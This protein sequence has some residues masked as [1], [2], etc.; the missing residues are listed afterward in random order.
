[1]NKFD[2]YK[3][4]AEGALKSHDVD[5]IGAY[6]LATAALELCAAYEKLNSFVKRF[7]G[8]SAADEWLETEI[9]NQKLKAEV[10][11]AKVGE[12]LKCGGNFELSNS[13][14]MDKL[15]EWS[16]ENQKLRTI[17]DEMRGALELIVSQAYISGENCDTVT[18]RQALDRVYKKLGEE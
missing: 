12:C 15:L 5:M 11:K 9:E 7:D 2:D 14:H 17:C 6:Q 13:A 18:A 3:K 16:K 1:M 10:E 8:E 4:L